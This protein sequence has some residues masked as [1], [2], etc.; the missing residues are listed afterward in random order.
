M[1]LRGSRVRLQRLNSRWLVRGSS[2]A[3]RASQSSEGD[4]H[5]QSPT[6]ALLPRERKKV[7]HALR[8][9]VLRFVA[10]RGYAWRSATT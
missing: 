6:E 7:A 8:E 1:R 5:Q 9:V 3:G 4:V 2:L 10:C